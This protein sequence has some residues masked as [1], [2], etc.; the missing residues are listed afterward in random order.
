MNW[1]TDLNRSIDYIE[2][3][4]LEKI[5]Y[6][7]LGEIARCSAFQY[8]RLFL[9][10][11]GMTVS[12]YVRKRKLS[13]AA[14]DL[15]NGENSVT[16]V[17]LKYGYSSPTAFNRAFKLIHGVAPSALKSGTVPVKTFAPI[18]FH[19][20]ISG[21][22]ELTYQIEEKP[23]FQVVGISQKITTDVQTNFQE[24]PKMWDQARRD[25]T[26]LQLVAL[27]TGEPKGMLGISFSQANDEG[28]Y[29]IAVSNDQTSSQQAHNFETKLIP[30]ATWA[31][32]PS[33]GTGRSIQELQTQIYSEWLPTSGY[34]YVDL[35]DIEVYIDPDP[36]NTSYQVW[37][38]ITKAQGGKER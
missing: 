15:Q 18:R 19:L 38:P 8:Q 28:L 34:K 26:I 17:A 5:N 23:A 4:L 31:I 7:K 3:T 12:E 11:S 14:V 16:D 25:G 20:N 10:M 37:V 29:A 32:F 1:T 36:Q 22:K 21:A 2:A 9:Y 6:K 13:L 35:P 30:A 33:Q 27:M 24:I